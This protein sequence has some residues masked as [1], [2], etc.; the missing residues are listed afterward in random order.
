MKLKLIKKN[1]ILPS[2]ANFY[3]EPDEKFDWTAGQY[4]HYRINHAEPDE[5]G[6]NRFFSI[7]SAPNEGHVQL[8]TKFSAKGSSF[9]NELSRLRVGDSVEAYGPKGD[10][11]VREGISDY[12]FIA[13]GIGITPF[14]SII[15][16]LDHKNMPLNISL[17][18]INR[19][20][21]I[22]FKEELEAVASG[23]KEFRINYFISGEKVSEEKVEENI[24]ILPGRINKQALE[25]VIKNTQ[26]TVFY[27]SGP[28]TMVYYFEDLLSE[29]GVPRG[30][31]VCDYY[32]GYESY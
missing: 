26:T 32:V 6:Q 18:Y 16:D 30:N 5:R 2:V 29:L 27:V 23:H 31:I 15:F 10:F 14:R 22:I 24:K 12:I 17:L 8:T 19:T 21:D 28:E 7:A 11:S 13:G 20:T 3:F 25:K 1:Q 4:L 9:K